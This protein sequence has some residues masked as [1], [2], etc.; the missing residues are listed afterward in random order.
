[1]EI[2][3]DL[4]Y[5]IIN[6]PSIEMHQAENQHF[7]DFSVKSEQLTI[8]L[9]TSQMYLVFCIIFILSVV[10]DHISCKTVHL[11]VCFRQV[12]SSGAEA[13]SF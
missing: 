13:A 3:L 5:T 4:N 8:T 10:R 11:D 2:I 9:K 6:I 1:M 12:I 7:R